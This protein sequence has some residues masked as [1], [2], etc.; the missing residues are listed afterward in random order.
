M[1]QKKSIVR[2]AIF[3]KTGNGNFGEYHIFEILFDNGDRGDF[4]SK[5]NPQS[6]FKEGQ[7]TEYTIEEQ[8]NGNY[9]NYKIKPVKKDGFV[10][11]KGNP[12]YEHKR[13]ALKCATDL[14]CAGKLPEKDLI[15]GAEKLMKFLNE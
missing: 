2:S 3:K 13:V 10:P 1:E 8:V 14:V 15:S 9:K 5:N 6:T 11:G 7:E 4:L 12:A